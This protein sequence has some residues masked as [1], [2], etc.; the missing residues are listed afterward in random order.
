VG[1]LL[2]TVQDVGSHRDW[3]LREWAVAVVPVLHAAASVNVNQS[4]KSTPPP[5]QA[6]GGGKTGGLGGSDGAADREARAQAASFRTQLLELTIKALVDP[7][8]VC[9]VKREIEMVCV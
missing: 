4:D 3:R 1:K 7:A 8:E 5:P 2:P 9:S 6:S